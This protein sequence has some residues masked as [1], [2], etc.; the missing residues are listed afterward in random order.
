MCCF[1]SLGMRLLLGAEINVAVQENVFLYP[2]LFT[3]L[4]EVTPSLSPA[5]SNPERA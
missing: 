3:L 5:K 2:G 4:Q 1:Q